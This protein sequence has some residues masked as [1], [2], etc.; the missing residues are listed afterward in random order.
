MP[1]NPPITDGL[2]VWLCSDTNM[3]VRP[4][5]TV[6]SWGAADGSALRA[7]A[8][9]S[10]RPQWLSGQLNGFPVLRFAGAQGLFFADGGHCAGQ[11]YV[12]RGGAQF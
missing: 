1:A 2:S 3:D 10:S 4:N 9:G 11:L 12:A 6:V 7:A 5:N 8:I